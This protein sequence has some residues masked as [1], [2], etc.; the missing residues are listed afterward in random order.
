MVPVLGFDFL[1]GCS[2]EQLPESGKKAI[3]DIL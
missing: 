3:I 2:P 1:V